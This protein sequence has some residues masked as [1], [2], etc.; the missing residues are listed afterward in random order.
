MLPLPGSYCCSLIQPRAT[1]PAGPY[2]PYE[3][4]ESLV[5]RLFV[6]ARAVGAVTRDKRQRRAGAHDR[7]GAS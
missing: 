4:V 1:P 2:H 5:A 3:H 7:V 6:V